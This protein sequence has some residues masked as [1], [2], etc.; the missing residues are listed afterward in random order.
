M[1][2][3]TSKVK[4]R[5]EV[6]YQSLEDVL[7]DA[8]RCAEDGSTS[9]GNWSVSQILHHLSVTLH[10]SIDGFGFRVFWPKR[11]LAR[12]FVKNK[13]L[14]Q[15]MSP[16]VKLPTRVTRLVP[17]EMPVED[18]LL[19]LSTAVERY[20]VNPSRAS[21]PVFGRFT[22]EEYDQFQL[23]HAELHMSFIVPPKDK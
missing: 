1:T 13:V 14:S 16:G 19:Q 8:R 12:I 7:D 11:L 10:A 3:D 5:R 17:T 18:A 22:S 6:H 2:V 4:G 15:G 20:Q 23:R 9:I 21:H